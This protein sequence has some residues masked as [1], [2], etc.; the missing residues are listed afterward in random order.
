MPYF[1]N[2]RPPSGAWDLSQSRPKIV[3]LQPKEE[4]RT[5][6]CCQRLKSYTHEY[7]YT[8]QQFNDSASVSSSSSSLSLSSS[9]RSCENQNEQ[10]P[11][12]QLESGFIR[13]DSWG[14]PTV[15]NQRS[16]SEGYITP[17]FS[18][19]SLGDVMRITVMK[20][21]DKLNMNKSKAM[22]LTRKL[23]NLKKS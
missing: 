8:K 9:V 21:M 12:L 22:D 18:G 16:V 13:Q 10:I 20:E 5:Q 19:M 4:P 1:D 15:L 6:K 7:S 11:T 2:S 23:W 14:C 3:I 17:R